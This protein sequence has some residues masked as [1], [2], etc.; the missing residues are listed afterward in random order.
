MARPSNQ[1]K[2]AEFYLKL[3]QIMVSSTIMIQYW[4]E[5]RDG[6]WLMV[7]D[8]LEGGSLSNDRLFLQKNAISEKYA[9]MQIGVD[10]I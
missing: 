7:F 3:S 8:W 2:N 10:H 1:Y 5:E 6:W 9:T 4:S